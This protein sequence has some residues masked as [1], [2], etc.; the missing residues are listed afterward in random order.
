MRLIAILSALAVAAIGLFAAP[1]DAAQPLG[2][3]S[4]AG[5]RPGAELQDSAANIY[6]MGYFFKGVKGRD[7]AVYFATVG[8][9]ILPAVG[10]RAWSGTSGPAVRDAGGKT[11]GHFVYAYR[12]DTPNADTFGVVRV[13][14]NVAWNASVCHFGG[15]TGVYTAMN[16]TPFAVQYYGQGLPFVDATPARTGLATGSGNADQVLVLGPAGLFVGLGDEGGPVLVDGKAIGIFT[17]GLGVGTAGVGYVVSRL[18]P[19]LKRAQKETG[20]KLT[21]QTSPAL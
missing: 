2:T 19:A 4:C 17:G 9:H 11:I 21:L 5:V 20:I 10:T 13:D 1:A 14:K 12:V 18:G 3:D 15:P 7:K 8:D 16:A 6:T